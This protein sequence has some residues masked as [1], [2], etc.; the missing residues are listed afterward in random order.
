M[1]HTFFFMGA[2]L[3]ACQSFV[4]LLLACYLLVL[5]PARLLSACV[6]N[7]LVLSLARLL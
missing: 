3:L 6:K 2:F 4:F 7:M 1:S 5:L